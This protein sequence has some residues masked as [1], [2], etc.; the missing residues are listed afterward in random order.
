MRLGLRVETDSQWGLAEQQGRQAGHVHVAGVALKA[1]HAIAYANH[2]RWLADCPF[3][4][5]GARMVQPGVDFWCPF[6]GSA[7][8]GGQAVPVDWPVDTD[9]ID[10]V[11]M[12]RGMER[13]RNWYPGETIAKLRQENRDHGQRVS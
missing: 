1:P 6:C 10:A 13:F 9:Q 12:F 2:G 4:C 5:G 11:L 3:N 7:D 8:A